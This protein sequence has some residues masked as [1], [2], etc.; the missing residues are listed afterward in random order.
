MTRRLRLIT[1]LVLLA[2]VTSHLVNHSLGLISL[3]A[4]EAGRIWFL[5]AWRS[6]PG[7]VLLIGSL[8]AHL[9]LSTWSLYERRSLVMPWGE[10]AQLVLGFAI[11]FLLLGHIIGTRGAHEIAG[12]NDTYAYVLLVHWVFDTS[13]IW[14]QST[15]L[16]VAWVHGC[17]GVH[18]WLRL[19]PFY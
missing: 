15:G 17:I 18:Y 16:V 7:T 8:M 10:A 5:A 4:M 6:P 19:K 14:Q 11:P 12:V 13:Y 1:G 2:Y 3:D 9:G